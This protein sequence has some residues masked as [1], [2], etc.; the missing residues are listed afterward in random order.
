MKAPA[1]RLGSLLSLASLGLAALLGAC[2]SDPQTPD[3]EDC[4]APKSPAAVEIGTGELCFQRLDD[5]AAIPLM[6]GPQGGYHL[7]LAL[8]C[9]D[10]GASVDVVAEVLDATTMAP[11]GSPTESIRDLTSGD[12]PQV[13][14]IQ[15]SMPGFSWDDTDPPPAEGTAILMHVVIK[16]A[17]GT[18]VLHDETKPLTIGPETDWNPC[19]ANPDGPC[20]GDDLCG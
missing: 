12:W 13:A 10:C 6:S 7:F 20:C 18:K 4:E 3:P 11:I 9:N 19:D 8:G 5:N 15:V 1:P 16:S 14:G 2:G 17:D